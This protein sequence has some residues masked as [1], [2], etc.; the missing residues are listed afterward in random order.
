MISLIGFDLM[1]LHQ[2]LANIHC[3]GAYIGWYGLVLTLLSSE[4]LLYRELVADWLVKG[5]ADIL[6]VWRTLRVSGRDSAGLTKPLSVREHF[7]ASGRHTGVSSWHSESPVNPKS[8]SRTPPRCQVGNLVFHHPMSLQV[9]MYSDWRIKVL[10]VV[11]AI[12][13]VDRVS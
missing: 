10:L 13:N 9:P 4:W 1:R 5:S 7:Q 8:V 3:I 12:H 11:Y 2:S 6:E